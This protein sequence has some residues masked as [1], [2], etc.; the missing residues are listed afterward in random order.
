MSDIPA[1]PIQSR[2]DAA[3]LHAVHEALAE[4]PPVRN[5]LHQLEVSVSEG[6]VKISGY[7]KTDINRAYV[8]GSVPKV[9]GVSFMD[10]TTLYS[11][12]DIRRDVAQVIPCCVIVNVEYGAVILSGPIPDDFSQEELV[13]HVARVPGVRRVLTNFR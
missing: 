3:I 8:A 6:S 2:S 9:P 10:I 4:Y 11:D 13:V 12:T 1:P 5:D 7:V